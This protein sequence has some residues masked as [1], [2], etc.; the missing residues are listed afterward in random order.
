M[1]VAPACGHPLCTLLDGGC[2]LDAGV[3][4]GCRAGPRPDRAIAP[5]VIAEVS[6]LLAALDPAHPDAARRVA[7]AALA[8]LIRREAREDRSVLV[9]AADGDL[10][11]ALADRLIALCRRAR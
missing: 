5:E 10:E 11:P 8:R 1:S 7:A 6:A 2:G 4:R 3:S 9:L